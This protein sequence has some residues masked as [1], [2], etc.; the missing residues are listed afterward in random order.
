MYMYVKYV[1][2]NTNKNL[3]FIFFL[4][5]NLTAKLDGN[6]SAQKKK[7]AVIFFKLEIF[8]D[9]TTFNFH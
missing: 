4:Y 2:Y 3:F 1:K 7:K 6:T 5:N 9:N 8:I